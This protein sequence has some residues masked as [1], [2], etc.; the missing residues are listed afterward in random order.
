MYRSNE[1]NG[2]TLLELLV[3]IGIIVTLLSLIIPAILM[4]LAAA[5]LVE[6]R[7]Q[8]RQIGFAC[9]QYAE[10]HA[11]KLPMFATFY[12]PFIELLPYID[13]GPY[14][15][16][17]QSGK[18]RLGNDYVMRPY[19][20]RLDPTLGSGDNTGI[21]SYAAN[22]L[23]FLKTTELPTGFRDGLSTTI[24]FGH[25]YAHPYRPGPGGTH[26]TQFDWGRPDV[27]PPANTVPGIVVHLRRATFADRQAGD[28]Y[29]VSSGNPP[30]TLGSV[31]GLTFQSRPPIEQSDPRICCSPHDNLPVLMADGSVQLLPRH[32][33][34]SVFWALV[35]PK[36]GEVV[37]QD[38]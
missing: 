2:F 1:R 8:M 6:C 5:R 37:E 12:P 10:D 16:E 19:L 33:R 7:N 35:T 22:A 14:Y 11:R 18:R 27:H 36:G 20:C 9:H 26:Y 23:I 3:V 34:E 38:W 13:H 24:L 32:M 15:Q 21:T 28:V 25:R 4:V 29:P 17:L 31:R 30:I